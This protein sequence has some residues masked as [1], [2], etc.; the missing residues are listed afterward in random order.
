VEAQNS[1][2]FPFLA[3][4]FVDEVLRNLT[5]LEDVSVL[6]GFRDWL[7]KRQQT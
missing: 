5:E 4:S 7:Q 2:A 6:Q 3:S 1:L